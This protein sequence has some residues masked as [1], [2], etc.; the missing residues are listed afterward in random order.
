MSFFKK[1]KDDDQNVGD[2]KKVNTGKTVPK[3]DDKKSDNIQTESTPNKKSTVNGYTMSSD[4]KLEIAKFCAPVI[5]T[6]L[7]LIVCM[8][9]KKIILGPDAQ[10][11]REQ[12]SQITQLKTDI[13]LLGNQYKD[14]LSQE[15]VFEDYSYY[16]GDTSDDDAVAA[17]FFSH[18]CTWS[19]S[20]TYETLRKELFKNGYTAES[21][22][23][24]AL[25]P[26][27]VTYYDD[28]SGDMLYSIDINNDNMSFESLAS[29]PISTSAGRNEYSGIL[30]VSSV[31]R[32]EG[33]MNQE[34]FGYVY[35]NYA[36]ENN[37]CT[38]VSAEALIKK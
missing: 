23:M 17:E 3:N 22:L 38:D 9:V 26:E 8:M 31:D 16:N 34:Y 28:A 15:T 29:Y 12:N 7:L 11:I 5:V 20:S 30:V 37:E 25:L 13:D 18:I 14:M 21:S 35:V 36:I 24:T 6:I 32:S 27:P 33:G 2:E 4:E 1:N 10:K 19:D